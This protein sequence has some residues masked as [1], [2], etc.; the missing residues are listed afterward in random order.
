MGRAVLASRSPTPLSHPPFKKRGARSLSQRTACTRWRGAH[1]E[2]QS[3]AQWATPHRSCGSHT[4]CVSGG[5]L[6]PRDAHA[7]LCGTV[8]Y[9]AC[10]TACAPPH[11]RR[12]PQAV[13]GWHP[14]HGVVTPQSAQW[15]RARFACSSLDG[16]DGT[17][18]VPVAH[19]CVAN[20]DDGALDA[21]CSIEPT[22]GALARSARVLQACC[23]LVEKNSQTPD[24]AKYM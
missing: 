20:A 19:T 2:E 22:I 6:F 21:C 9:G 14:P 7:P 15:H 23:P 18:M 4:H 11:R 13:D 17:A 8:R 3:Q 12:S 10:G 24:S 5:A 16:G 1:T